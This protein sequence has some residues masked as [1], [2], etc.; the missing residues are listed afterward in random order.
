MV[1]GECMKVTVYCTVYNHEKYIKS[2]LDG[3]VMQKTNFDYE[4]VV[5]DDAS[6]MLQRKL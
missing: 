1:G 2:A 5:H 4:V 6:Q 3:F